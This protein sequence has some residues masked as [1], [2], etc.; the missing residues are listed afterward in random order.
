MR[1]IFFVWKRLKSTQNTLFFFYV[2]LYSHIGCFLYFIFNILIPNTLKN[3]QKTLF[4]W[5][6]FLFFTHANCFAYIRGFYTKQYENTQNI[7][8]QW[9]SFI[10]AYSVLFTRICVLYHN[11]SKTIFNIYFVRNRF[12]HMIFT[13]LGT[14]TLKNT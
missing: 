13:I 6:D 8:F 5:R 10:S 14:K 1:F 2:V 11:S 7:L 9:Y 12:I 4:W 3:T